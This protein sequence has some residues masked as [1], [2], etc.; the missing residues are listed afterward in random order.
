MARNTTL[1]AATGTLTF[2]ADPAATDVVTVAGV[3][4]TYVATPATAND[5]DVGATRAASIANLVAAINGSGSAS[6]TTYGDGTVANPHVTAVDNGDNTV[7]ITARVAGSIGNF[8][9]TTTSETDIT[10]GAAVLAS[11]SGN[12][13]T[14]LEELVSLNQMNSEVIREVDH[15]CD[16]AA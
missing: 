6:A 14:F 16:A 3:A 15:A 7:T 8:I 4:Y 5:I 1:V 12:L 10:F 9:T 13:A 11:G 2:S